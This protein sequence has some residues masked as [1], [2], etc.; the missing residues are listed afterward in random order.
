MRAHREQLRRCLCVTQM[1]QQEVRDQRQEYLLL[2]RRGCD[3][4]AL[5]ELVALFR[6]VEHE[7]KLSSGIEKGMHNA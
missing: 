4:Q 1:H 5:R 6:A 2:F 3:C 7:E